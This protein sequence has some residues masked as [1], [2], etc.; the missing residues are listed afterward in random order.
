MKRWVS[1]AASSWGVSSSCALAQGRIPDGDDRQHAHR[2][3]L[4]GMR[5]PRSPATCD[6]SL[7]AGVGVAHDAGA[8]VGGQHALELLRGQRGAV[9]DAH[10][11]GVDRAPDAHAA[12]VMDGDP[13]GAR[14]GVDQ[15]VEQRPVGDRVRAVGHRLGLAIGGGHRAGVQVVA[16]DHDRRRQL[17]R[18]HHLVE[19]QAQPRALA[20]PE[21]ADARRQPLEGDAL[22]GR[23]DPA[24]ERLVLGEFLQHGAIRLGDVRGVAGERHPAEGTPS[25]AEQ[26]SHVGRYEPGVGEGSLEAAQQ[27]LRAQAVAVVEDLRAGVQEADHGGTVRGH[28][29]A[30]AGDVLLRVARAQRVGLGQGHAVGDVAVERVVGARLVGDDVGL[31][32]AREQLG[33]HL[34]GVGAQADATALGARPWPRWRAARRRRAR[35]RPRRGSACAGGARCAGGRP[36]RTA[37]RRR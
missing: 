33:Q 27:R 16:P 3:S 26:R 19:A 36:R 31:E 13:G 1:G 7:V 37:R 9:G 4:I 8:R 25:L 5:T 12:S 11:S 32:A 20:V 6:R 21:P 34:G 14:G 35:T 24:R 29:A 17:A 2:P 15:R 10:H 30:R 22:A 18:G 28:R 23:G